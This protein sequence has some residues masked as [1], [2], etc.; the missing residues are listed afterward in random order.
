LLAVLLWLLG[1]GPRLA[2]WLPP[3]LACAL[4]IAVS[5]AL[6]IHEHRSAGARPA[7]FDWIAMGTVH[8]R[9]LLV[10]DRS[11]PASAC[12]YRPTSSTATWRW[13]LDQHGVS[14]V[15]RLDAALPDP[16]Q[17]RPPRSDPRTRALAIELRRM[18]VEVA[19]E[20]AG[21]CP[22]P[23]AEQVRE[24]LRECRYLQGGRGDAMAR[25]FA[26]ELHCRIEDRWVELDL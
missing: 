1:P 14:H 4:A 11:R 8:S 15:R 13:L 21:D 7:S 23:T 16:E 26:R 24:A 3:K 25:M 19:E 17:P 2:A 10:L 20:G 12:L 22:V 18:G 5:G 6:M 9:S